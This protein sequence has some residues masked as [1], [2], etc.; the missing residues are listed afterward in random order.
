MHSSIAEIPLCNGEYLFEDATFAL[1]VEGNVEEVAKYVSFR[2]PFGLRYL[3]GINRH[4]FFP[5]WNESRRFSVFL[6][7]LK[8]WNLQ[9]DYLLEGCVDFAMIR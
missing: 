3:A 8:S 2:T 5:S 6:H 1:D 7:M 4:L 9:E